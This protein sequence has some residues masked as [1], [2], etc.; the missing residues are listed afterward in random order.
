[1]TEAT[2]EEK[3]RKI[4]VF[5]QACKDG[6]E[7]VVKTLLE[8][9]KTQNAQVSVREYLTN[10]KCDLDNEGTPL[11]WACQNGK[12][13]VVDKIL[14][15]VLPLDGFP[16]KD[17]LLS[18]NKDGNTPLHLACLSGNEEIC[19]SLIHAARLYAGTKE[20][21]LEIQRSLLEAKN[22]NTKTPIDFAKGLLKKEND[23]E[24]Q[25]PLQK[26]IS[27]L[28]GLLPKKTRFKLFKR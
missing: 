19:G 12:K 25:K 4:V 27:F 3:Q 9:A 16:L 26:V 28:E 20:A 11:H 1:M 24:R 5:N 14:Q 22:T 10:E 21:A 8:E 18:V 17:Y 2:S 13:K 7:T 6:K 15:A 23:T